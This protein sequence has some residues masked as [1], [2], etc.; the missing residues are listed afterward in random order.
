MSNP[1]RSRFILLASARL[2]GALLVMFGLAATYGR[3]GDLPPAIGVAMTLGGVML[4]AVVPILLARRWRS[5]P[6]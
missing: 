5:P 3:L 1:A 4:F 2:A 6:P